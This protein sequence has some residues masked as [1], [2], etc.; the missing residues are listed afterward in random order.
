VLG[1]LKLPTNRRDAGTSFHKTLGINK[2]V[3]DSP[4]FARTA[5]NSAPPEP[6][7]H[8]WVAFLARSGGRVES[9]PGPAFV[10]SRCSGGLRS[11]GG[12]P[13]RGGVRLDTTLF[14]YAAGR[15]A[16]LSCEDWCVRVG[17]LVRRD[18]SG[19]IHGRQ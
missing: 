11:D 15:A 18:A 1:P 16:G 4:P 2:V 9:A 3:D 5:G 13:V 8:S 6:S 12:I 7:L 14:L 19:G 10:L 17:T